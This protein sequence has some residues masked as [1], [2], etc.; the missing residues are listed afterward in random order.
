MLAIE[1][2]YIAYMLAVLWFLFPQ[3]HGPIAAAWRSAVW[4]WH[5]GRLQF[6]L[7]NLGPWAQEAGEV[8][9]QWPHIEFQV[10]PPRAFNLPT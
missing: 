5:L 9:G 10:E 2:A 8:R 3:W 6:K 4:N 7:A 1:A